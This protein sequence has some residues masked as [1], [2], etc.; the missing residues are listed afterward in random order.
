M[1]TRTPRE[2]AV[3]VTGAVAFELLQAANCIT[4]ALGPAETPDRIPL[5]GEVRV[6]P[7]VHVL[8]RRTLQEAGSPDR[9]ITQLRHLLD[10]AQREP[11]RSGRD[12]RPCVD[13]PLPQS[14]PDAPRVATGLYLAANGRSIELGDMPLKFA[15]GKRGSERPVTLSNGV[16]RL[17]LWL[18]V[19]KRGTPATSPRW[20]RTALLGALRAAGGALTLTGR[21][22]DLKLEPLPAHIDAALRGRMSRSPL[23][24][25]SREGNR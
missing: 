24:S 17:L 23:L 8:V 9:A 11:R 12:H 13:D 18:A 2:R 21:G 6:R 14:A 25:E 7:G 3:A 15:L 19:G 1:L 16:G 5:P 20:A 4:Q 22:T 10:G